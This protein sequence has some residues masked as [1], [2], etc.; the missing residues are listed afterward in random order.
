MRRWVVMPKRVLVVGATGYIGRHAV[1][2]LAAR[3]HR[4]VAFVRGAATFEPPVEVRAGEVTAPASVARDAFRG[5]RFDAV[6]S[7]VA[8]RSGAPDDAWRV[9][10]GANAAVLEAARA[11]GVGHFVLLSALCV[12]RP[13]LAF[14]RAK[15]AFE[16][17]LAASGLGYSIV[18]PTAFFKSLAGQVER[19]A[20]GAPF[21]C[22]GDGE[23]TAC[24]PIGERDLAAYLADCL[25]DPAKKGATL[26]VG[27]PGEPVTPRAQGEL[28]FEL[29]GRPPR[30]RRVPVG[31]LDAAIATMGA[32]GHVAAAARQGRARAHR[33]LL[34]D[35]VDARVRPGARALRCGGDALVRH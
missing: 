12:Q 30:F 29:T 16:R 18:R 28:L 24:K 15:L 1:R 34:R 11:A 4:V 17:A 33:S 10:Y 5:E 13:R 25:D 31:L 14:Q 21:V 32:L 9:D 3:G 2:E 6:V 20:R 8:S 22:F 19:V 23:L 35:R 27:G 26:P 7:C